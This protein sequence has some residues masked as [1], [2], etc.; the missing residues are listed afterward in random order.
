[1][2]VGSAIRFVVPLI[3][4]GVGAVVAFAVYAAMSAMATGALAAVLVGMVTLIIAFGLAAATRVTNQ[5]Q[6]AIVLRLGK[7]S[8]VRG[9]GLFFIALS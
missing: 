6:R 9:P 2:P 3:T 8:S 7:F 4:I 5:W 1:M